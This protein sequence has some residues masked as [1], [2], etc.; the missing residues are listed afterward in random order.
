MSNCVPVASTTSLAFFTP[1]LPF[2]RR[3]LSTPPLLRRAA[4]TLLSVPEGAIVEVAAPSVFV[5]LIVDN[6]PR[7]G[8]SNKLQPC[9]AGTAVLL[10]FLPR[11]RLVIGSANTGVAC[12]DRSSCSTVS[13]TSKRNGNSSPAMDGCTGAPRSSKPESL[14]AALEGCTADACVLRFLDALHCTSKR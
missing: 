6:L 3:G 1:V 11:F 8:A 9:L 4:P 2:P 7:D 5:D 10:G 12:N 13:A 14:S